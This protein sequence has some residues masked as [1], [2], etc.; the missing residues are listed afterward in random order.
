MNFGQKRKLKC[1]L[2]KMCIAISSRY[3]EGTLDNSGRFHSSPFKEYFY[4]PSE[5]VA[6]SGRCCRAIDIEM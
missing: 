4:N 3:I 1:L 5:Y 6:G 2:K